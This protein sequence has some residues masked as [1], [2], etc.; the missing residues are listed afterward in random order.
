[1]GKPCPLCKSPIS[2]GSEIFPS[3]HGG[4]AHWE[5][6]LDPA[7]GQAR[8]PLCKHGAFCA[9]H[10]EG[11]CFFDH[12][13]ASMVGGG[14][15]GSSHPVRR[16]GSWDS[17]TAVLRRW[18]I[19][20]FGLELLRSGTGVMEVAAGKGQLSFELLHVDA[21]PAF[22]F[23]P[24]P[25]EL[26]DCLRRLKWGFYKPKSASKPEE[27][28]CS[29][30]GAQEEE[31]VGSAPPPL[32][33][34]HIRAPFAF[35]AA[36]AAEG[37]LATCP[38]SGPRRTEAPWSLFVP[39]LLDEAAFAAAR[40]QAA[41]MS[42]QGR[43]PESHAQEQDTEGAAAVAEAAHAEGADSEASDTEESGPHGPGDDQATHEPGDAAG[44]EVDL[45]RARALVESCSIVVGLHPDEATEAAVDF[46]LAAGKPFA[47][48]PCCVH[49]RVFPHR[50]RKNG[51]PVR[52]FESFVSYLREKDEGVQ[53]LELPFRG[54]A[55]EWEC[56]RC[57]HNLTTASHEEQGLDMTRLE[58]LNRGP[59]AS[60]A[61]PGSSCRPQVV[62]SAGP[63]A[64]SCVFRTDVYCQ[65][66]L[67]GVAALL[68]S[69]GGVLLIVSRVLC[70]FS[71]GSV[72]EALRR[73]PSGPVEALVQ[74]LWYGVPWHCSKVAMQCRAYR[75]GRHERRRKRSERGFRCFRC[76]RSVG[77]VLKTFLAPLSAVLLTV[78]KL[79]QVLQLSARLCARWASPK[80]VTAAGPPTPLRACPQTF[81]SGGFPAQF[82][83]AA[84]PVLASLRPALWALP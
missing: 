84:A 68:A 7:S 49:S 42:R 65:A 67:L 55:K 24:L 36:A 82:S 83:R 5:C 17:R 80:Y 44:V 60:F 3:D 77:T 35:S 50:S 11:K 4:W 10:L 70:N 1:L 29:A 46:A 63:L 28:A 72:P 64:S 41:A 38:S 58:V 40:A 37:G 15:A 81:G 43:K 48:V 54:R 22:A 2:A 62:F 71:V 79:F 32:E 9:Q 12:P 76:L 25:L 13:P 74:A 19:Q 23:E 20:E 57:L 30:A 18:L 66:L 21:V 8:I 14:D 61:Q 34:E 45:D 56:P 78:A 31:E 6:C 39:A 27:T 73:E 16:L 51:L 69:I 33:L 75:R 26:Q 59:I 47:V 52:S 53:V